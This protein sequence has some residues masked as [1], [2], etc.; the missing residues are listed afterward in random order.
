MEKDGVLCTESAGFSSFGCKDS[1]SE[2]SGGGAKESVL[3]YRQQK[4]RSERRRE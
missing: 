1:E 3:E 2:N 4:T